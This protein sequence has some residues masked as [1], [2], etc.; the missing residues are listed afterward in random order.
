MGNQGQR[1]S[2]DRARVA[3]HAAIRVGHAGG[4]A[5][6]ARGDDRYVQQDDGAVLPQVRPA[7]QGAESERWR[8]YLRG[9]V[10]AQVHGGSWKGAGDPREAGAGGATTSRHVEGAA[11]T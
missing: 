7:V 1:S 6:G 8:G 11:H 4:T 2:P 10:R 9:P 5:A 3:A